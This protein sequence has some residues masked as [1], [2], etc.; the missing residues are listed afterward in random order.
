MSGGGNG[1]VAVA[2]VLPAGI[3]DVRLVAGTT[4]TPDV[5]SFTDDGSFSFD[6]HADGEFWA[7]L[8]SSNSTTSVRIA[9]RIGAAS[10]SHTEAVEV[11]AAWRDR[12]YPVTLRAAFIDG[13]WTMERT[14]GSPLPLWDGPTGAGLAGKAEQLGLSAPTLYFGWGAFVLALALTAAVRGAIL[15]ARRTP[16]HQTPS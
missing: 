7:I 13:E 1:L 9:G 3:Q 8:P 16:P 5:V 14:L 12:A 6:L 10:V 11:P 15:R 2:V 4:S